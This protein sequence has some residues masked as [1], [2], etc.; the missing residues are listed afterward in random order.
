MRELS[1]AV[2]PAEFLGLSTYHWVVIAATWMGWG[3]D[4]FDALLF[5][6]VA[7]NCIPALVHQARGSAGAHAATVFWTGAITS[8]LLVGWALGALTAAVLARFV[9]IETRGRTLPA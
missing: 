4:L 2:R 9:I 6:F 5:N 1:V 7:P 8:I 3:F